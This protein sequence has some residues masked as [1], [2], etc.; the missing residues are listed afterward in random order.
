MRWR[1]VGVGA[2]LR[3]LIRVEVAITIG[4]TI[5]GL[6]AFFVFKALH[7]HMRVSTQPA[8]HGSVLEAL[9]FSAAAGLVFGLMMQFTSI[10][11]LTNGKCY[12]DRCGG[13]IYRSLSSFRI[14]A[15]EPVRGVL[16]IELQNVSEPNVRYPETLLFAARLKNTER[17]RALLEENCA[18]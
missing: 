1:A 13:K 5:F 9:L 16:R 17:I 6:L 7:A 3:E 4:F 18:R 10:V 14:V 8:G 15:C 2:Y 11:R 12:W